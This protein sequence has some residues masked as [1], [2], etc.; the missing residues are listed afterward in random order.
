MLA[1]DGCVAYLNGV[2]VGR[3]RV[4]AENAEKEWLPFDAVAKHAR[5]EPVAPSELWLKPKLLRAGENILALQGLNRKDSQEGGGSD[6][7]L[8]P[9]LEEVIALDEERDRKLFAEFQ[10]TAKGE[11]APARSAYFEGRILQRAGKHREAVAK[12]REVLSLDRDR[13]EPL[14]RLAE[15]LMATDSDKSRR[16]FREELE[17]GPLPPQVLPLPPEAP[18]NLR[19]AADA[20]A[21]DATF[22]LESTPFYHL[23]PRVKHVS[24]RWQVRAAGA[25]YS[26]N[27]VLDVISEKE[28]VTLKLRE[29]LLLPNTN[30][31]WR[32]SHRV[33]EDRESPFSEETPFT[34]GDYGLEVVRFDLSGHFNLDGVV[35]P[36]DDDNDDFA[37]E[38]RLLVDG[39]D[40][41]RDNPSVRGLPKDRAVGVHL[42]GDYSDLNALQLSRSD[43]NAVRIEIPPGRY[44][45]VRFLVSGV[46]DS[47]VPVTFE[48]RDGSRARDVLPCD[49]W[50]NDHG[51]IAKGT[52]RTLQKGSVPVWNG[53]D[54]IV[55]DKFKKNLYGVALF[56]VIID[57]QPDK[58]LVAFV[59]GPA[60]GH[61]VNANTRFHLF[62]VT[63]VRVVER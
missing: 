19:P 3:V 37:R 56:E 49:G 33:S 20:V 17:G 58:E 36:G 47:T 53:M 32:V 35:D 62:A 44:V 15:S 31:Y 55:G 60:D 61:F 63:G 42:L 59:L 5:G 51:D 7:S 9:V 38:G 50:L 23:D 27:P 46:N 54:T 48:Y 13:T 16:L 26:L 2:E 14:L 6:F 40:G 30:Y 8:I 18:K 24:T 57:V 10:P 1:D 29:G 41:R 52:R 12:F 45:C 11:G 39:F 28:L 25:D 21:G 43:T 22:L 34:T 4:G